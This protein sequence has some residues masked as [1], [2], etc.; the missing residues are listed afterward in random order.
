[1]K[2][3]QTNIIKNIHGTT[4]VYSL[5]EHFVISVPIYFN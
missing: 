3:V 4:F 2:V 1:M 5:I